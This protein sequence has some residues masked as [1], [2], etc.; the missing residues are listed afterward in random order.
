MDPRAAR[1]VA[2]E[3]AVAEVSPEEAELLVLA[4]KAELSTI[5]EEAKEGEVSSVHVTDK[6]T[7]TDNAENDTSE[8]ATVPD[9]EL[10]DEVC[11]DESY[12]EVNKK[13]PCRS[14]QPTPRVES[15]APPSSRGLGGID[16]YTKTYDEEDY[17]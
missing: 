14:L 6:A 12:S 11:T 15:E 16:Y 3:N 5:A 2:A 1:L 9:M 10:E 7:N 13:I 4:E 17:G 8:K